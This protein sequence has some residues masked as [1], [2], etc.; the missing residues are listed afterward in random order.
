M[1]QGLLTLTPLALTVA[2]P[3]Q[4]EDT[5]AHI[6][7]LINYVPGEEC[8]VAI[9]ADGKLEDLNEERANNVSHVGDIYVGRVVNVEPSIQAAFIDF[10][11]EH[12]GFLHISDLHPQYFPGDGNSKTEMVGKKTPRRDRPPIQQCLRRGQEITVQVL[13]EGIGT[14]GPTLTSYLSIPGRYL[15]MMPDMDHVGLSRKVENDDQR[16]KMRQ[17]IDQ[18]TLPEGFGFILRTAGLDRTK[19]DLKRDLAYLQRLWK[20]MERRRKQG[21]KPRL[22]YAESDLLVRSLRDQLST[23]IDEVVIDD[24]NAIRRASRFMKIVAPRSHTKLVHFD[25]PAPMYHAFGIEEQI[26]RIHEREVPLPSGGSLV[27]DETEALVAIDVNSGKMRGHSDA[28]TTAYKT[29]IEAIE[30]ICRQLRLRDLG[31]LVINDLIDMR[32]RSHR[33]DIETRFRN[34]LKKDRA[35]TKI[36]A[37]SQFG[38]VEMTRQRMRGS[39]RSMHSTQCPQ[40]VGRGVVQRPDSVASEAMRDLGNLIQHDR[41]RRV[42][43]VVSPRVASELLSSKRKRLGRL[44]KQTGKHIDVRVS[45]DLAIDRVRF[46]AYDERAAD[47]DISRLPKPKAPTELAA[48]E[49]DAKDEVDWAATAA[50]NIDLE[51]DEADDEYEGLM[52]LPGEFDEDEAASSSK[53]KRKRRRGRRGGSKRK[54][55]SRDAE[56]EGATE[57][58]KSA[59]EAESPDQDDDE[60]KP[61]PKRRR[62]RRGGR[63]RSGRSSGAESAPDAG[64]NRETTADTGLRGDSWDLEPS[65][66]KLKKPARTKAPSVGSD[67]TDDAKPKSS[68]RKRTRSKKKSRTETKPAS[69]KKEASPAP[70][71]DSWDLEPSAVKPAK[72]TPESKKSAAESDAETDTAKTSKKKTTRKKSKRKTTAKKKTTTRKKTTRSAA[73]S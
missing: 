16:R 61:K 39:V 11:L 67:E 38:I 2:L 45:E 9:V 32:H 8:R 47:I 21:D 56:D 28:E 51:E 69:A 41:V 36:L 25:E 18:L 1:R 31:G 70:R 58:K 71:G 50:L 12:N 68:S 17:I 53:K 63:K 40:C 72:V 55:R 26:H 35:R 37:I 33:K 65:E 24:R 20:D 10:G 22:L 34:L 66:V 60:S 49:P 13:K 27:F 42:V 4:H 23:D 54:G 48:W 43:M 29:N 46:E 64:E 3:A 14:K 73:S 6:Q 5:V 19:T 57:S 62:G 59:K 15:V 7:M 30:E 52:D 44:E